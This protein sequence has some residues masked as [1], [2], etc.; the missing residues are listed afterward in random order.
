MFGNVMNNSQIINLC[1][2]KEII[3][4][5]FDEH[6]LK[7]AHYSL[8]SRGILWA[9]PVNMEGRRRYSQRVDFLSDPKYTFE[10]G[11]YAILEIEER[12]VLPEGI[13]GQF[14]PGSALIELGFSLTAG[15]IDPGYG[16]LDGKRQQIRFGVKNLKNDDNVLT[17]DDVI[18]H[19]FFVDL[20]GLDNLPFE[21]S[22]RELEFIMKRA[23]RFVK[24]RDD[25]PPYHE[26]QED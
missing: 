14:V 26:A 12:I 19:V 22:P 9:G 17:R 15:K 11:E 2:Q 25:G 18:A 20:R 16:A 24:H 21:F 8:T 4:D 10:A 7:L 23:A 5:P 1:K 6:R 13:V 3:I